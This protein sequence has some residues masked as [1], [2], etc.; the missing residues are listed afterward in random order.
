MSDNEP[1][2]PP[3]EGDLLKWLNEKPEEFSAYLRRVYALSNFEIVV[4]INGQT[5]KCPIK[6]SETNATIEINLDA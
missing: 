2:P 4:I 6:F 5:R 3:P 1:L